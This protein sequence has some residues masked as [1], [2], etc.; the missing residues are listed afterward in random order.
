MFH[1]IALEAGQSNQ[2]TFEPTTPA[3]GRDYCD[4]I[5]KSIPVCMQLYHVYVP[6]IVCMFWVNTPKWTDKGRVKGQLRI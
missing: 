5:G 6:A 1:V 3:G 4:E 2:E